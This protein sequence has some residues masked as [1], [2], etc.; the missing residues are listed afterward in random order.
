[1]PRLGPAHVSG[2]WAGGVKGDAVF[3]CGVATVL[4]R[5]TIISEQVVNSFAPMLLVIVGFALIIRLPSV[6]ATS[7]RVE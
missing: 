4:Q 6:A 1:M 5:G 2:L 3:V 7:H